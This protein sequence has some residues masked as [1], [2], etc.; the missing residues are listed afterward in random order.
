VIAAGAVALSLSRWLPAAH[1]DTWG[2][3]F[4][5]RNP[6]GVVNQL[7]QTADVVQRQQWEQQIDAAFRQENERAVYVVGMLQYAGTVP[8]IPGNPV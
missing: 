7:L 5:N 2:N 3:A 6:D 4:G 8:E 1:A